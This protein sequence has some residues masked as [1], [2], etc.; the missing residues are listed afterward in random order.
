MRKF[1]HKDLAA[2]KWFQLSLI[3]QMANIGSEISRAQKWQGKDE[4]SFRN[5]V[6]RALELFDLTL[7][8]KRWLGR[9]R[10]IGR[11]R[12]V[13]LDTVFGKKEYNSSLKE[14]NK[15]FFYFAFAAKNTGA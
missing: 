10:E 11:V 8:D 7:E 12:E 4:N 2:G 6:Y 14:L 3:E 5:A 1:L 15:Y 13:F 9:L